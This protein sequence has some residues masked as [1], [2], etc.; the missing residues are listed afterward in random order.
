MKNL[1]H[2]AYE[3]AR[4]LYMFSQDGVR[5]AAER[6]ASIT[7]ELASDSIFTYSSI[8]DVSAS[9]ITV[10]LTEDSLLKENRKFRKRNSRV[11]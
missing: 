5:R 10:L 4:Y 6:S 9:D 1:K 3:H 7:E 2:K 11:R 8:Q